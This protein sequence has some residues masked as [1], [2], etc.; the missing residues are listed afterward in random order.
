MIEGKVWDRGEKKGFVKNI[1]IFLKTDTEL[2]VEIKAWV[3]W[4][5]SR[6]KCT[7][8]HAHVNKWPQCRWEHNILTNNK[9]F[10]FWRDIYHAQYT[11]P[12]HWNM[13]QSALSTSTS[14]CNQY[15]PHN[16][17]MWQSTLSTC[18]GPN[19]CETV[20]WIWRERWYMPSSK[21]MEYVLKTG[22]L[23]YKYVISNQ[24]LVSPQYGHFQK[25]SAFCSNTHWS[26]RPLMKPFP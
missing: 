14:C 22:R 7:R 9:A 4:S 2:W 18:S 10:I 17:C 23:S 8:T 6:I 24:R 3:L 5:L 25:C 12:S 16:D 20:L 15:S 21:E 1:K 26:I 19:L 11:F 13:G